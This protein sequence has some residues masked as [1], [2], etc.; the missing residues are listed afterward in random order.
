MSENQTAPLSHPTPPDVQSVKPNDTVITIP[1]GIYIV[2][3]RTPDNTRY[4]WNIYFA[5]TMTHGILCKQQAGN[6][7]EVKDNHSLTDDNYFSIGYQIYKYPLNQHQMVGVINVVRQVECRNNSLD[8]T[9]VQD[10]LLRLM[11]LHLI[12]KLVPEP[13]IE[14]EH[15]ILKKVIAE[16]TALTYRS[17]DGHKSLASTNYLV[18]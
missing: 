6:T 1:D 13:G 14:D 15:N 12:P 17:L 9:W 8:Y 11:A 3:L 5:R 4:S 2:L 7:A 10:T 16:A 18:G